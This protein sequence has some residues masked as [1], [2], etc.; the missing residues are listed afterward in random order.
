MERAPISDGFKLV[1]PDGLLAEPEYDLGII[2]REDPE[3]LLQD[4]DPRDR[5]HKLAAWTGLDAAD[6]LAT[7]ESQTQVVCT[8]S[9]CCRRSV[10]MRRQGDGWGCVVSAFGPERSDGFLSEPGTPIHLPNR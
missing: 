5:A 7:K 10:G 3:E 9:R 2:M 6:H 1:D 4:A 8:P